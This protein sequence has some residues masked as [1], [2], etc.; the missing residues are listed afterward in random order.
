MFRHSLP[1]MQAL[2]RQRHLICGL[3]LEAGPGRFWPGLELLRRAPELEM[4]GC[5]YSPDERT[6]AE[7]Q[8]G[9]WNLGPRVKYPDSDLTCLPLPDRSVDGVISYGGLH[10]WPRP[11]AVVDE[12]SRVLKLGGIVLI[13]DLRREAAG[14][15]T[16]LVAAGHPKLRALYRQRAAAMPYA[17]IRQLALS[18]RLQD[19]TLTV[20][21]PDV[22]LHSAP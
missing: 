4:V 13:G 3:L 8:A 12:I 7:A 14:L 18:S 2:A 6:A 19:W 21:G 22:W 17:E 5:G 15:E 11:L 20:M 9:K 10:A 16:L 1:R